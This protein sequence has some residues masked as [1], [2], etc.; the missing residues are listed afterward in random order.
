MG[1]VGGG[2]VVSP[3]TAAL[4][5]V[6]LHCGG[7]SVARESVQSISSISVL[8]IIP[9]LVVSCIS[10]GWCAGWLPLSFFGR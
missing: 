4:H 3:E 8:C 9:L 2:G 10:V 1:V 5:C 7:G 6:A